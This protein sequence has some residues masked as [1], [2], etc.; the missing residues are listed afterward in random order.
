MEENHDTGE[1]QEDMDV[2]NRTQESTN[3]V[4]AGG[5]QEVPTKLIAETAGIQEED[6]EGSVI[7]KVQNMSIQ[8][9]TVMSQEGKP[10]E[11]EVIANA[12]GSRPG[13]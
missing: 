8:M 5:A 6:K 2:E 11:M 12:N 4:A 13:H 7:A 10:Q 1:V 3:V 9:D